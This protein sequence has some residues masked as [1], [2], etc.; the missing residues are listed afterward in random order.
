MHWSTVVFPPVH[1]MD[2]TPNGTRVVVCTPDATT[3]VARATRWLAAQ[4]PSTELIVV[5]ATMQAAADLIRAVSRELHAAFGWHRFTLKRLAFALGGVRLAEEGRVAAGSL[6]VEAICAR[7]VHVAAARG[8]LGRFEPIADRP[9]LSRALARSFTELRLAANRP[10]NF[11]D[12]DLALLF[13]AYEEELAGA[14]LADRADLLV[15]AT[16]SA[17]Q[18]H[19]LRERPMLFLDVPVSTARELAFVRAAT[20]RSPNVLFTVP[21]GDERTLR[22]LNRLDVDL[23]ES[24][25]GTRTALERLQSGLFAEIAAR[26]MTNEGVEVF[27]APGESRECVELARL[28]HREAERG[29]AFDRMAVLLRSPL[30]YRPHLEEA[31]RRADIPAHFARGTVR[32]DPAGRAFLTLLTC[33]AE[34]LSASRFAEF[35]SIGQVPDATE[36]GAPPAP[37]PASE[38]WVP[39]DDE[40]FADAGAIA[41]PSIAEELADGRPVVAGTLRAPRLWER[42][43]VDAAVIGGLDRWKRRLGG[44]RNQFELDLREI[45]DEDDPSAMRLRRDQRGLD[46]LGDYALPLLEDLSAFPSSAPWGDWLDRLGAL[47]TRALRHPARVLSVL[48]EL[49]PMADVGPVDLGE[50]R[51]VLERRLTEVVVPPTERRFGRIYVGSTDEARGLVFDVVFVPGLAEK[52]FPQK[53]IEDPIVP[54]RAREGTEL[55][56]NADRSAEERLALRIA[57]GAATRRVVVSYPRLDLDQSRPRTPSFY[58]LEVLRAAEGELPGFAEL[59][60]RANIT[61]AA[62]VGWPA[63]TDPMDAIDHAEHDLALLESVLK[64]PEAETVGTARFLLSAN[65]HLARALRFRGRRWLRKWTEADGIVAPAA[66]AKV[67]LA[68]HDLA[69]RSY[70]PTG[71]QNYAACPYRF[72]LQAIHRLSPREQP[73][74]LEELD[75]LHKGSL[76]HEVQ[77]ELYSALRDKNLLPVTVANLEEARAHLERVLDGVVARYADDLAPAIDRVWADGI[78]GVRADLREWLR[79]ASE[80]GRWT[81]LFFELSFGLRGRRERDR[82]STQEP[83][84][85]DSGIKLR[86]S[87]DLVE[88]SEGGAL[89]ATDHKTGK[90]RAPQGTVIGGGEVLQPVLYALALEKLLGGERVEGGR[91]YYCTATG[92]FTDVD[93]PLDASARDAARLVGDTVRKAISDGFLPAAPKKGACE[94][95]DYLRVCGPYEEQRTDR[96]RRDELVPLDRLRSHP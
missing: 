5:G 34:G 43:L 92:E 51:I 19:P 74:P 37:L 94:Y 33:A 67:A 78:A 29:V 72:V 60:R 2:R 96:K 8:R 36:T 32:P 15:A 79:R 93:V 42:L 86:G 24:R 88:K 81:P 65:V 18:D 84:V 45:D 59:A 76:I 10:E 91:L 22:H 82:H 58:G 14:G 13:G 75:P 9:G 35:L 7:V 40:V 16:I 11:G 41:E 89:R 73:A 62:R 38:R 31:F 25:P 66:Q 70:S 55:A 63:P 53:V 21:D 85:L 1:A 3:R 23:E 77:F 69:A 95:C 50:V 17:E 12:R 20:A 26:P 49:A 56:T 47:A 28:I 46:G 68:A 90:A 64:R 27:S 83:A 52:L 71:L 4:G 54:D 87:I 44:L 80:D 57:I 61:G 30:Q 48:G 39:P 6:V